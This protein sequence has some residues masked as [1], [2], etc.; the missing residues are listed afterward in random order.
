MKTVV[1]KDFRKSNDYRGHYIEGALLL[2]NPNLQSFEYLSERFAD[3]QILRYRIPDFESIPPKLKILLYH[4]SEAALAGRDIL[5]DQ[6]YRHNLVIRK[7]LEAIYRH[8]QGDREQEAFHAFTVYLKRVWFSNGIHHHY[9]MDKFLPRFSFEDLQGWVSTLDPQVLPL[10]PGQDPSSLLEELKRP[11][12]DPE[13]DAKKVVKD[14]GVDLVKNSAVNFYQGVEQEEVESFYKQIEKTDTPPM[15]GLNS[16][17]VKENGHLVEKVW[18]CD[19]LY[20]AAIEQICKHLEAALPY[21][22][23]GGQ[24]Q[25]LSKLVAFYKTGDLGLFDA[26]SISWVSD[27]KSKVDTINGFIEV[28]ND[29]MGYR[30]S[31]E[32]IVSI[33]DEIASKRI[34]TIADHAQWFEDHSPIDKAHKKEKVTGISG[35]VINV[36]VEAG[37]CSPYTPIGVNLPNSDWIREQYGSKSVNL[38]NITEAYEKA[39]GKLN[40]AFCYDEAERKRY[41]DHGSLSDNLHTDLHEAVG[42]ASGKLCPGVDTPK[43]TLKN[44][45]NTLEEARADLVA[46][47]FALDEKLVELELMPSLE[48]GEAAYDHYIRNGLLMQL[49]RIEPGRHLEEDHLRNRQLIAAWAYEKGR[50]QNVIERLQK[51]GKTY[52][53]IRDYQALRK[54]FGELLKEIQ[55]IKSEGDFTAGKALVEAYGVKVDSSLHQEVL[56][57]VK[58]LDLPPYMGFIN[59]VLHPVYKNGEMV[60]VRV[61]Y[62]TSFSEQMLDYADRYGF[63]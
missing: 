4:L 36:V 31:Y 23:N 16:T 13:F 37:D 12:F 19:G 20:G 8:Y 61:D 14:E 38:A 29:P 51:E 40:E 46:L 18:K 3:L 58:E 34:Q 45:A 7:L 48:V 17:M 41:L 52:F 11:I 56:D 63:L 59:P 27:T 10:R 57:R 21:T 43:E 1:I 28:Y 33:C 15:Y 62:P 22:E 6:N 32:A 5:W 26:Y 30:G 50:D 53:V 2:Q 60:D 35:R 47:Y 55:R 54:L 24:Y 9:A 25:A 44:Y 39:G 49:R 42:H